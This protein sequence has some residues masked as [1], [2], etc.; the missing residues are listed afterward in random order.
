MP[1]E[2]HV[3]T[4]KQGAEVWN[5]WRVDN[6]TVRPDL[7]GAN[8]TKVDLRS[9]DL[10]GA[11]LS[12]AN[13]I[14]ADLKGANLREAN[15][16]KTNLSSADL[17]GAYL[18]DANIIRANF[19]HADLKGADLSDANLNDVDLSGADLNGMNLSQAWIYAV[20]FANNDL[21]KIKGLES[22]E[23]RGPS[24]IGVDTLYKSAGKIPE[25][26]LRGCGLRDWEIEATKLYCRDLKNEEIISI[27]YEIQPLR[28]HQAIQINP[29]F[30]SYSHSDSSFVDKLERHLNQ[31]GIRFWRDVHHATAGRLEKQVDRAMRLNPIVLLILS[32]HSVKSDWVEHE[33][34]L[35]RKLEIESGRDVLCPITLDDSWKTSRWPERLREQITEYNILDFSSW[36]DE[37]FLKRAFA[38]LIEG[39]DLFYK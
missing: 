13:L 36:S 23:H 29:L 27:L 22:V 17:R 7:S 31:T 14:S 10:K 33:V 2:D 21:G 8:L 16:D 24:T 19:G 3:N 12:N 28:A 35:A 5:R 38:K 20:T 11:D 32:E 34:R 37:R 18:N 6:T 39:L 9:A 15:L 25:P 26:F 1:N 30:I 4:V